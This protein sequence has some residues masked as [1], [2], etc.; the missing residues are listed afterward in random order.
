MRITKVYTKTGDKG[1]T[2]LADGSRVSKTS[3]RLNS[4]GTVDELNTI[5]GLCRCYVNLVTSLPQAVM[6]DNW[7]EAIQNDLFNLGADLATPK[8][9][10]WE[11]M[12]LVTPEDVVQLEKI[13]DLCQESLPPLREFIL[14]GGNPLTSYL[15]VART[16]CRR[17]E[18]ETVLLAAEAELN[19]NAVPYLNRLSDLFFVLSRWTGLNSGA[20][21]VTWGKEKG[22]R[23]L[24][25]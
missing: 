23:K 7:L 22:V 4:Y 14:P 6:L 18:R 13:I 2:G 8:S 3:Q 1:S 15:H 11:G 20:K 25:L 5:L 12:L 24:V 16:I 21:E 17:A 10:R 19:Q 9:G